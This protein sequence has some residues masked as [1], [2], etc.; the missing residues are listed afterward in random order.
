MPSTDQGRDGVDSRK[1][2]LPSCSVGQKVEV[3]WVERLVARV[4]EGRLQIH[5]EVGAS[6]LDVQQLEQK[7][8]TMTLT[9]PRTRQEQLGSGFTSSSFSDA[10]S[11]CIV[12]VGRLI[13]VH[14]TSRLT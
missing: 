4:T 5:S 3:L 11:K 10:T 9:D 7:T 1:R 14:W 8:R 6:E 12:V 2:C 13:L